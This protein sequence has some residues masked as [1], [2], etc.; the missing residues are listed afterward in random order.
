[1]SDGARIR[2]VRNLFALAK[3]GPLTLLCAAK[4]PQYN[5]T[6]ILYDWLWRTSLDPRD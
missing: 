4:D 6:S 3:Q 5:H 2:A 1:M